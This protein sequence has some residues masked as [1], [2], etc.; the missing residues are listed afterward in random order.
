MAAWFWVA[1]LYVASTTTGLSA[2][3][4]SM[5]S[6]PEARRVWV[7]GDPS[8]PGGASSAEARPSSSEV[9]AGRSR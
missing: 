2:S 3:A 9:R 1:V 7:C 5:D 8:K 4:S 6:T